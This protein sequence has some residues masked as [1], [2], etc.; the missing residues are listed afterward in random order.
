MPASNNL[1]ELNAQWLKDGWMRVS[2]RLSQQGDRLLVSGILYPPESMATQQLKLSDGHDPVV[3]Y[4]LSNDDHAYL[5]SN[6]F[7]TSLDLRDLHAGRVLSMSS[8]SVLGEEAIPWYHSWHLL[9]SDALPFPSGPNQ[10]RISEK[11]IDDMWFYFS[12]G[13]FVHKLGVVLKKFFSL[14]IGKAGSVLDWGCGCGRL[15]RHLNKYTNASI[16]GTDIDSQ[17]V[18]WCSK[19]LPTA[20][21]TLADPWKATLYDNASFDL[22]IGHS[23][24]THLTEEAQYFWLEE[25]HRVLKP[26]GALLV[27]VMSSLSILCEQPSCSEIEKLL[28]EGYLDIG[29]QPDGVDEVAPGYYRKV[30]HRPEYIRENWSQFFDIL[31]V[32]DG[33]ADHQALVVCKKPA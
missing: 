4:G 17:N 2:V 3:V 9:P 25:L 22:I 12:G 15:T 20:S 18:Q 31:D 27:T 6:A 30:F 26:G 24:F 8:V 13:T 29:H 23:V 21:F 14:D 16:H 1:N 7:E 11:A 5:G 28:Q 19:H 32:L 10:Q 33:Y